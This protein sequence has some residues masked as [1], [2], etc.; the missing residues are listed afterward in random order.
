MS[1]QVDLYNSTYGNFKEQ[2]LA[3]IRRET[4]GEDIGQNSWIT[5]EEY[6]KFY[7]WLS[8]SA[9]DHVL[10]IASGSGGPA[11]YLAKKFKCRIAGLDINEEGIKTANQ[12]ARDANITDAKF[13]LADV[14]QRLPFNDE[15]FDAVMCADSMNHFRDRL[16]YL[17]EWQRV[18]KT[19]QRVL[20]T[21][22]V[23]ITG[24][25]SNEE[26]AA[27]S[28]IGFFLFV[29]LDVTKQYIREAGLNLLR[30]EDVTG[31]IEL[32]SGR[33]HA[34]RQKHREDLIKIEGEERFEGLQK[35]FST[36]HK[37]TSERRLSRF[38]FV[39]EK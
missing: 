23:V 31:N 37:L 29:P 10:E 36:V 8:L 14:N 3:E 20:F 7:S 22:P 5:T 2:V 19:G 39:A 12:Q 24:P 16:G 1:N 34:S 21:D 11:L 13:Q 25:V 27:R 32:T 35:F 18:L 15:T 28:N 4:Y 38:V 33:W 9:G 6:D 30:C 26:L 17:Q